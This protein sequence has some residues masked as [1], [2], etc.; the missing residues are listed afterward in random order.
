MMLR[1]PP[2]SSAWA[3]SQVVRLRTGAEVPASTVFG[4]GASAW[5]WLDR[6]VCGHPLLRGW[7]PERIRHSLYALNTDAVRF[8]FLS[9]D[10]RVYLNGRSRMGAATL[11]GVNAM[12]LPAQLFGACAATPASVPYASEY[13]LLVLPQTDGGSPQQMLLQ[14]P[15]NEKP[16]P[17]AGE[18]FERIWYQGPPGA[19][20]ASYFWHPTT[21]LRYSLAS[22]AAAA[23]RRHVRQMNHSYPSF[24]PTGMVAL[25][26]LQLQLESGDLRALMAAAHCAQIDG[27]LGLSRDA[28]AQFVRT[29]SEAME[30]PALA[31]VAAHFDACAQAW[32]ALLAPLL[33]G[34]AS[35]ARM[36]GLLRHI[37]G[38]ERAALDAL[39][40]LLPTFAPQERTCLN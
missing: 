10:A 36:R 24:G 32:Q 13:A 14:G 34:D 28:M 15:W 1:S 2:F 18:H 20:T 35:V 30:M 17:M 33:A 21:S 16:Y 8:N 5:Y 22:A 27:G 31:P 6:T 25:A 37:I 29:A 7:H 4:L 9:T 11:V 3:V 26:Q 23:L 39:A 19:R 40:V 12:A 38:E